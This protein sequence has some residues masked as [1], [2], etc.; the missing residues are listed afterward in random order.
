MRLIFIYIFVISPKIWVSLFWPLKYIYFGPRSKPGPQPDTASYPNI[1]CGKIVHQPNCLVN[2]VPLTRQMTIFHILSKIGISKKFPNRFPN[3]FQKG[4]L[5]ELSN[6][7]LSGFLN[8]YP[9]GVL[10]KF[11]NGLSNRFWRI[12]LSG[13][14]NRFSNDYWNIFPNRIPNIFLN[15][16]SKIFS[17]IFYQNKKFLDNF[18]DFFLE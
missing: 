6:G 2:L 16:L 5:K 11:F 1:Q 4:F 13:F 12:F 18:P 10:N 14:P 15:R 3:R 7:F 9:C 8:K 17:N